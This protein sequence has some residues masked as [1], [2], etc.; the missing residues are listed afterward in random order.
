MLFIFYFRSIQSSKSTCS[1]YTEE[2]MKA[3][4]Q[5]T[6]SNFTSLSIYLLFSKK[7][8]N[9]TSL[10]GP[11]M[12]PFKLDCVCLLLPLILSSTSKLLSFG[13]E[14]SP[15]AFFKVCFLYHLI[16]LSLRS[17]ELKNV[18]NLEEFFFKG[19]TYSFFF[20]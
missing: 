4:I 18:W 14:S 10:H 3:T 16:L 5:W 20:F 15:P 13:L 8:M 2:S 17:Q 12:R 6:T 1:V 19:D 9:G 7:G 11:Q